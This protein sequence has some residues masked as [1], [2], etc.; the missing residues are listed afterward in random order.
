MVARPVRLVKSSWTWRK[1][2]ELNSGIRY[3]AKYDRRND[4]SVVGTYEWNSKWKFGA[5]F[6]YATGNATSL[7]ERFYVIDGV[8]T[9]EY[10]K[11]NKTYATSTFLAK[12]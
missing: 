12:A 2:P 11:I 10:S 4:L 1:F 8:L 6:I 7:P 9:Q 5:V 3:P